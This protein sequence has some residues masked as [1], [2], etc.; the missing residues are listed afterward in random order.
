MPVCQAVQHAHQKGIIH[1]DLKPSNVL[2]ALY[3]DKPGAQGHRLRRG[4][5]D[6]PAADRADADRPASARSSARW[7]TCAPEQAE[8]NNLDI[9]TRSDIYSLGVLLYELLTGT[10]PVDRKS[11]GKAALLEMLRIVREEEPPRP[12]TRL[13]TTEALPSVAANRETEPAKLTRLVRGELDWIVM[14]A[15]EKDRDAALRDGQRPGAATSSA[16][17]P[18]RWSRRGR[19]AAGYRL[20]KFVRRHKGQVIAASLVLLALV[21]GIVGT[22]WGYVRAERARAAEERLAEGERLARLDAQ[23]QKRQAEAANAR[24]QKRLEQIEKGNE[25]LTGIFSDLNIRMVREQ[26]KPLE[27]VLADRLV[28][29]AGQLEGESVGDPLAVATLQLRL[30][31]SLESLG[32]AP[33]AIPVLEKA[34]KTRNDRLGPDHLDTMHTMIALADAYQSDGRR[35]RALPLFEE[36]WRL[37]KARFGPD[38]PDTLIFMN[39]LALSGYW[40]ARQFDRA[41]PLWEEGRRLSGARLG[42]DHPQTLLFTTN[43]AWGYREIGQL[44]R[45]V[46]LYEELVPLM[47]AKLGTDNLNTLTAMANLADCYQ[48]AGRPDRAVPLFEEAFRL[49]KAAF[50]PDHSFTLGTMNRL[51]GAMWSPASPAGLCRSS[52]RPGG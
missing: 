20:Q 17:W 22:T 34:R 21:A 29:A 39:A 41:L 32:F 40:T 24:A 16:T 25:V 45:A 18:T 11:L 50:G 1:R 23:E 42:A 2:V 46:T 51:G 8:L 13:S 14:K 19:R 33:Q 27:R 28:Q 7:S 43:L 3:D 37:A 49:Q 36:A 26:G 4:Q 48:A 10:T 5:G 9:D 35:D 44:D 31:Q 47:K 52:R 15:L 6:R 12:S 38:H 30:G